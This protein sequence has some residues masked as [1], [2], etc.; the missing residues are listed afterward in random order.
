[1]SNQSETEPK[2]TMKDA[3][4]TNPYTGE[5]FGQTAT[6]DRGRVVAVDGGEADAAEDEGVARVKDVDHTPR[7]DAPDTATVY[8][9]GGEGE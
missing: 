3:S 1:M 7:R 6:Y 4:H 5:T 9:R 8:A 2:R